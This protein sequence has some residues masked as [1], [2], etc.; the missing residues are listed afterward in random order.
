VETVVEHGGEISR[1]PLHAPRPDR[2]DSRLLDCLEYRARLL[3]ARLQAPMNG[4]IMAGEAQRNRIGVAAHDRGLLR[5]ELARRLRQPRLAAGEPRPFRRKGD[6]EV[7]V[8]RDRAQTAGHRPLE[9]FG[10]RILGRA[11]AFYVRGHHSALV[12]HSR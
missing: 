5:I 6:V 8:A 12:S 11:L 3:A 2:L 1:H 4:R 7:V 9:R 10:R